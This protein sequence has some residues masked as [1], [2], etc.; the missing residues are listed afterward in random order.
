MRS[1]SIAVA[2][3]IKLAL[4]KHHRVAFVCPTTTFARPDAA[5]VEPKSNDLND[6]LLAAER[7]RVRD[8]A[9]LM[10]RE[11]SR[12]G[13]QVAFAG[14]KSA[15]QMIL[16]EMDLARDGRTQVQGARLG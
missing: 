9:L 12:L 2:E 7:A 15:I 6:L 16:A 8:I 11:L 3:V 14:E 5:V 10:K 13:V 4:A 1:Q